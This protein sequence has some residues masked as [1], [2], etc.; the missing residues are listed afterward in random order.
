[1]LVAGH[2]RVFELVLRMH[3]NETVAVVCK[4]TPATAKEVVDSTKRNASR[5]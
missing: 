1:M 3:V 4:R 2:A 5:T